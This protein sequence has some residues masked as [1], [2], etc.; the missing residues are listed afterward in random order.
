MGGSVMPGLLARLA[1][2]AW[3]HRPRP[4]ARLRLALLY[5]LLFLLSGAVL[6]YHLPSR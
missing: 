3:L 2:A 1:P 5:S 4:T 6:R